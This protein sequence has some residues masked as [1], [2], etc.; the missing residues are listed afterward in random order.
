[1]N[2]FEEGETYRNDDQEQD[3]VVLGIYEDDGQEVLLAVL[4]VDRETKET[5]GADELTIQYSEF[6]DWEKVDYEQD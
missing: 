3:A 4:W 6:D 5:L 1:M 2:K